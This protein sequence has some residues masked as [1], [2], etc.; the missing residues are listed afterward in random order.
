MRLGR[1]FVELLLGQ[2]GLQILLMSGV[3]VTSAQVREHLA[4]WYKFAFAVL[5]HREA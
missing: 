1:A 2:Q 5:R 4:T 3:S